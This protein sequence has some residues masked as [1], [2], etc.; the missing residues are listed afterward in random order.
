M[1][2]L[3]GLAKIR[4]PSR[5]GPS[6]AGR[7]SPA[8]TASGVIGNRFVGQVL[9]KPILQMQD[10][11]GILEHLIRLVAGGRMASHTGASLVSVRRFP[12]LT[13]ARQL[14]SPEA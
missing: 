12:P 14:R 8:P 13:M 10:E 3:V 4:S 6:G 1:K 11:R 2:Q 9:F 5:P 7:V